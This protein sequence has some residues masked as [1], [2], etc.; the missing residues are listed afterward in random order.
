MSK[1]FLAKLVLASV[2]VGST[3]FSPTVPNF[4]VETFQISVAHAENKKFAAKD[5]AMTDVEIIEAQAKAE[6]RLRAIEAVKEQIAAYVR[7]FSGVKGK[8]SEDDIKTIAEDFEEVGT[9]QYKK[10]FYNAVD[11]DGKELGKVGI[12]YEATV[13]AKFNS[14]KITEYIK[15]NAKEK[16]KRIRQAKEAR[17]KFEELD[18]E[19]EELRKNARNKTPEQLQSEI[20]VFDDKLSDLE[21][22]RNKSAKTNKP[23]K[24]DKPTTKQ[25]KIQPM[26]FSNPVEIGNFGWTDY[27]GFGVSINKASYISETPKKDSNV[28]VYYKG[29]ARFGS[30]K[31]AIYLHYD[32]HGFNDGTS[33]GF[34]LGSENVQNAI[35][36]DYFWTTIFKVNVNN[37]YMMYLLKKYDYA[38]RTNQYV[39]IGC[40]PDGKWVKYFDTEN[41][42]KQYLGNSSN[43]TIQ[44]I[45]ANGDTIVANYVR[46][47]NGKVA[48]SGEFRFKWDEAAKWFGVEKITYQNKPK[49]Q[50][51]PTD[52]LKYNGHSYYI[53]SNVT[54]TWEKAKNYC[55]SLGGHLAVINDAAENAV[56]FNYMK[57]QGYG[58]AYFGLSD[59]VREGKWTWVDGTPVNYTNWA[60]GEPNNEGANE[61]YAEF[62][63]KF[64]DGKWN[65]GN[66]KKGTDRDTTAFICEWESNY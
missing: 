38:F 33:V 18:R 35:P 32:K 53:Y 28:L 40:R 60:N 9:A 39:L 37:G 54:D 6:S 64:N 48:E 5:A 55:E 27:G 52:A 59:A 7:N 12:M 41:L 8:L 13:Q 24:K 66:F 42:S 10:L 22:R 47:Q 23:V 49:L 36:Y 14:K 57:S 3:N 44:K 43:V 21:K 31:D 34:K 58:S 25:D 4:G 46:N 15:L 16:E 56:L 11:E 26:K 19:Y 29:V 2:L 1:K 61:N 63:W 65:D 30:G 62:Y 17:E 51:I 20:K 45:A 50:K